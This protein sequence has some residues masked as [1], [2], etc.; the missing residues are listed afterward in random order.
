MSTKVQ[1]QTIIKWFATWLQLNSD[2]ETLEKWNS[3]ENIQNF[4]MVLTFKGKKKI[5]PNRPKRGITTYRQWYNNNYNIIKENMSGANSIDIRAEVS[6]QWNEF[7]TSTC[8]SVVEQRNAYD[9][10][11]SDEGDRYKAEM[12]E[13]KPSDSNPNTSSKT[14]KTKKTKKGN[15]TPSAYQLWCA[16]ERSVIKNDIPDLDNRQIISELGIRWKLFQ[17]SEKDEDKIRLKMFKDKAES[18]KNAKHADA[19][20]DTDTDKDKDIESEPEHTNETVNI[21]PKKTKTNN[22][23]GSSNKRITGYILYCQQHRSGLVETNPGTSGAEITKMLNMAWKSLSKEEQ[24][25]YKN[26]AAEEA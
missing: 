25:K 12:K 22:K 18:L 10:I 26:N 4:E 21:T 6:R 8:K 15:R 9:K 5:D 1:T 2:E 23:F 13:Y 20:A 7:K 11:A 14:K 19:D 16:E 17:V 24:D 3:E